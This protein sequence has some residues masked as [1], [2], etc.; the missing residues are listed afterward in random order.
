MLYSA[1]F[2]KEGQSYKYFVIRLDVNFILK[3]IISCKSKQNMFIHIKKNCALK[4]QTLKSLFCAMNFLSKTKN[5]Y[6]M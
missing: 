3:E 1:I 5:L 2:K 4:Q 6:D